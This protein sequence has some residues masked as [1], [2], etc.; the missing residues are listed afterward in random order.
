LISASPSCPARCFART[1]AT[2]SK[3]FQLVSSSGALCIFLISEAITAGSPPNALV[4]LPDETVIDGELV[5][6][7]EQGKPNFNLLQNYRSADSYI[8]LYAFDLLVRRG[9]DV[10]K[11]ALSKRREILKSTVKPHG[12]VVTSQVSNQT[13][14]QMLAFVK[15]H[16]M[17]GIIA[18][19]AHSM[20]EPGRR[21][22]LWVNSRLKCLTLMYPR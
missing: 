4:S 18:K 2:T 10:T 7:N 13:A 17:E 1:I 5:A 6:L 9:E 19:R 20:Y 14:K 22:G 16:G 3:L 11:E 21:S 12:H 15:S 8:M